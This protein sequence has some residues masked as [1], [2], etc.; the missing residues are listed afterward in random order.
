M[1]I[2]FVILVN[3]IRNIGRCSKAKK[4]FKRER[5]IKMKKQERRKKGRREEGKKGRIEEAKKRRREKSRI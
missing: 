3:C 5:I 1:N 2:Y 4:K